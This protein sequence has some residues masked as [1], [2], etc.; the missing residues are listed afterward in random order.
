MLQQL[1]AEDHFQSTPTS[2]MRGASSPTAGASSHRASAAAEHRR[3]A[4]R[5]PFAT[6][7]PFTDARVSSL[8]APILS[9]EPSR[10][11]VW[12]TH[13]ASKGSLNSTCHAGSFATGFR[14]TRDDTRRALRS[15][16]ET[17][18]AGAPWRMRGHRD[19]KDVKVGAEASRPSNAQKNTCAVYKMQKPD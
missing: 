18:R 9:K 4:H 15:S 16:S 8:P 1:D 13:Q 2:G 17:R 7:A 19:L 5:V 12:R 10:L 6:Q 14:P 11:L 3:A